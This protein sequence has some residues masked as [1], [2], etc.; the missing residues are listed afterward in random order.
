MTEMAR[1][2]L[3]QSFLATRNTSSQKPLARYARSLPT[4]KTCRSCG[5]MLIQ[6]HKGG[7]ECSAGCNS[8][9]GIDFSGH[10]EITDA[11]R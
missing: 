7:L 2:E 4:Y 11:T 3:M 10:A 9:I 5:E 6:A 1:T 8:D